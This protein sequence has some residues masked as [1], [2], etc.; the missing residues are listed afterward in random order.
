[1]QKSRDHGN[2][3]KICLPILVQNSTK[4]RKGTNLYKGASGNGSTKR[5]YFWQVAADALPH[6]TV[7][8]SW[9]NSPASRNEKFRYIKQ[10]HTLRIL[11]F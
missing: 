8:N 7:G 11:I 3:K 9:H 6:V 4:E 1:M 5:P 10:I 2:E